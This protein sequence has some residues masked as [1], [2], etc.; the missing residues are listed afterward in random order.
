MKSLQEWANF[1]GRKIKSTNYSNT[2]CVQILGDYNNWFDLPIECF[3][4]QDI[5]FGQYVY[6]P[7]IACPGC[8]GKGT[9]LYEKYVGR[10]KLESRT[11]LCSKCHGTGMS[12]KE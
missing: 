5:L 12:E 9:Y 10:T 7:Q 3:D 1:T 11:I 8:G 2:L 4:S 6:T